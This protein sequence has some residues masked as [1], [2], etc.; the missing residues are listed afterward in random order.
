MARLVKDIMSNDV[1][2]VAPDKDL[3]FV[4]VLAEARHVRHIA[5]VKDAEVI[6]VVSVRDILAHLSKANA[7]HFIPASEIMSERVITISPDATVEDLAKLMREYDISAVPVIDEDK[8]LI[9][10]VSERDF[11][12]LFLNQ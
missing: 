8:K 1:I 12:K 11:L 4:E 3:N 10:M 6:A 5:V 7:S 9:G 2:S